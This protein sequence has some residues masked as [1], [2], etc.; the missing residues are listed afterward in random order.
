MDDGEVSLMTE[1]LQKCIYHV[2]LELY[3]TSDWLLCVHELLKKY[4]RINTQTI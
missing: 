3:C 2:K 1:L 4:N